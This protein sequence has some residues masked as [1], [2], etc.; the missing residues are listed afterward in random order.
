M[1]S[2]AILM[3]MLTITWCSMAQWNTS[4]TTTNYSMGRVGIGTSTPSSISLLHLYGNSASNSVLKIE[5]ASSGQAQFAGIDFVSAT[6]GYAG[7]SLNSYGPSYTATGYQRPD[8]VSLHTSSSATNGIAIAARNTGVGGVITFHTGGDNERIRI[9]KEGY[10]GVNTNAPASLLDIKYKDATTSFLRVLDGNGA[11]RWRI[12]PSFYGLVL[13]N[14]SAVDVARIGIDKTF[15]NSGNVGIGT[16]SP[17]TALHISQGTPV[18]T[19]TDSDQSDRTA[20]PHWLLRAR[21]NGYFQLIRGTDPDP[22]LQTAQTVDFQVDNDGDAGFGQTPASDGSEKMIVYKRNDATKVVVGNNQSTYSSMNF[23]TS[24]PTGGYSYVQAI[25]SAGSTPTFGD[26][27][28]NSNGGNVGIGNATP[29]TLLDVG[30]NLHLDVEGA[31]PAEGSL[32]NG[33]WGNYIV[34][35][36]LGAGGSYDQ[37]LRLGVTNGGYT[38]AEIVLNNGNATDGTISFKTKGDNSST[39]AKTKM[40][41]DGKGYVGVG[42]MSSLTMI[43]PFH[44]YKG[45]GMGTKMIVGNPTPADGRTFLTIGTSSDANGYSFIEAVK[46]GGS[47]NVAGPL[48]LN[49]G[50]GFVGIGTLTPK[51]QL[52]IRSSQPVIALFD[53]DEATSATNPQWL[54][55]A[56]NGANGNFQIIR[57]TDSELATQHVDFLI[58]K[59]GDVGIG[60]TSSE[61][62]TVYKAGDASKILVGNPASGYANL[63]LGTNTDAAGNSYIDARNG[64]SNSNLVLNSTGGSVGIGTNGQALD[65]NHKLDVNGVIH[66]EE[67]VVD[68]TVPGPDYVFE[69]DYKLP[70]LSEIETFVKANKHL[71]EVPSAQQMSDEGI[72]LKEMNLLLLKKVEELTLHLIAKEKQIES[73]EKRVVAVEN[74]KN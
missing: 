52:H 27:I 71:P 69:S 58:D 17:G 59:D 44:V 31:L 39:P 62:L 12:E 42:D 50:G 11:Q 1:K 70:A 37:R 67:V 9:S 26:F 48:A 32:T 65:A 51:A 54:L 73:L 34:G 20:N 6:A 36:T 35:R 16:N 43:E 45:T 21:D 7:L 18:L 64:T 38:R 49:G 33:A 40:F 60:T 56:L 30:N 66:A 57:S 41:I 29:L 53:N 68:L 8:G 55:R 15:F 72:N 3:F 61:K 47:P 25:K 23:G 10:L 63:L 74:N 4:S 14:S 24:A 46:T 13:T 22:A 2:I 19:F 5:A 28:I